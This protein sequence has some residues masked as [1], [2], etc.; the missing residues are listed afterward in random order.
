MFCPSDPFLIPLLERFSF[1]SFDQ[2]LVLFPP[3]LPPFFCF[4]P[5][6]FHNTLRFLRCVSDLF[7]CELLG[8]LQH[9]ST[10]LF[11]FFAGRIMIMYL[12][13]RFVC[14]GFLGNAGMLPGLLQPLKHIYRNIL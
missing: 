11:S 8:I 13:G 3:L 5:C 6:R 14:S 1:D 10:G 2:M 7:L 4:R 9:L 12:T